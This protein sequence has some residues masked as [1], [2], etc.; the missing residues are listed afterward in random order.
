MSAGSELF[1][2]T[3]AVLVMVCVVALSTVTVMVTISNAVFA[4]V[5][6]LQ[7]TGGASVGML[8]QPVALTK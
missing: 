7:V 8:S 2:E 6:R 1:E 5:P 4:I 3:L